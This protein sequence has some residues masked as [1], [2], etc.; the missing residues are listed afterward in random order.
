VLFRSDSG[1]AAATGNSGHAAAGKAGVACVL[2]FGGTA[3]GA[4][5][6]AISLTWW[7][8]KAKRPRIV[9]GY[10]G[11]NG[12]EPDVA[13]CLDKKHQFAKVEK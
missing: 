2:G 13:Y 4:D 11:E 10:I 6:A 7:D 8:E 3:K 1:H 5:G 9:V 12:L